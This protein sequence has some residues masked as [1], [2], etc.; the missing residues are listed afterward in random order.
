MRSIQHVVRFLGGPGLLIG[1]AIA[2]I[3]ALALSSTSAVSEPSWQ[4]APV[5]IKQDVVEHTT[6]IAPPALHRD[7][8][9][10]RC[11]H[12]RSTTTVRKAKERY[13]F[14]APVRVA[15]KGYRSCADHSCAVR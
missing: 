14:R 9:G 6:I 8:C 10:M 12:G 15:P 2:I 7:A 3:V 11:G 1:S 5:F 4:P 13:W